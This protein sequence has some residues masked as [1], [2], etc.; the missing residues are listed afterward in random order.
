MEGAEVLTCKALK[1]QEVKAML[2]WFG[3]GGILKSPITPESV[4]EQYVLSSGNPRELLRSC[5]RLKY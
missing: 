4:T 1:I 5:L 3:Q 2:E